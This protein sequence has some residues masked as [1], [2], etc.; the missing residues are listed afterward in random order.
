V[1][2][3]VHASNLPLAWRT[4]GRSRTV[5]VRERTADRR[6]GSVVCV[7]V[8]VC[9]CVTTTCAAALSA[10]VRVHRVH[11]TAHTNNTL[12]RRRISTRYSTT[13]YFVLVDV[14][15][16]HIIRT[17]AAWG[18]NLLILHFFCSCACAMH[19]TLQLSE[20]LISYKYVLRRVV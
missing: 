7:C 8:C 18:K 13:N 12:S 14:F 17:R 16:R 6:A 10:S 1:R 4:S 5:G 3:R 19:I 9:V 2:R 11:H 20:N 15:S